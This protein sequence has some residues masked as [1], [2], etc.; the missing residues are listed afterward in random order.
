M[1]LKRV[2]KLNTGAEMPVL[3]FGASSVPTIQTETRYRY[4]FVMKELLTDYICTMVRDVAGLPGRGQG[5]R[6]NRFRGRVQAHRYCHRLPKREG[7]RG[8]DQVV[9]RSP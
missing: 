8:R 4:R 2:V 5:S 3:G 6:E 9:W 1:V 7:G